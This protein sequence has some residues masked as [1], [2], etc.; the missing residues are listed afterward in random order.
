MISRAQ[1]RRLIALAFSR[2]AVSPRS[3]NIKLRDDGGSHVVTGAVLPPALSLTD[4]P[5]AVCRRAPDGRYRQAV[6]ALVRIPARRRP[7]AGD[8]RIVR[9]AGA[10]RTGPGAARGHRVGQDLYD[11]AC[12]PAPAAPGDRASA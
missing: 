5:A 9:G 7:A 1:T 10:R 3:I 6:S 11:G 8:R 12:D 4:A 2:R